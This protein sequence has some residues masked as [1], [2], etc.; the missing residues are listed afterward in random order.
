MASRSRFLLNGPF[1]AFAPPESAAKWNDASVKHEGPPEIDRFY[2]SGEP[3][4]PLGEAYETFSRL[5]IPARL[6]CYRAGDGSLDRCR[7]PCS[8]ECVRMKAPRYAGLADLRRAVAQCKVIEFM[9]LG[10]AIQAEPMAVGS[11]RDGKSALRLTCWVLKA[12]DGR[13]PGLAHIPY[14]QMREMYPTGTTF[15]R[16]SFFEENPERTIRRQQG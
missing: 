11:R 8:V 5:Q 3:S 13:E 7:A 1:T 9:H 10:V 14:S 6:F 4:S 2:P 16:R 12:S 15:T